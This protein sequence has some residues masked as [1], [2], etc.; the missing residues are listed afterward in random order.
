MVR[1]D[2]AQHGDGTTTSPASMINRLWSAKVNDCVIWSDPPTPWTV[3]FNQ[4]AADGMCLRWSLLKIER[5][6]SVDGRTPHPLTSQHSQLEQWDIG[7]QSYSNL[8]FII[9]QP[10]GDHTTKSGDESITLLSSLSS[11]QIETRRR[12]VQSDGFI[13]NS[14]ETSFEYKPFV[15]SHPH[16]HQSRKRRKIGL[17]LIGL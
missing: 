11:Y 10:L 14:I 16:T 4:I 1:G 5:R 8:I 17:G 3:Y 7:T 6:R 15:C 9:V 13:S 2:G 12:C